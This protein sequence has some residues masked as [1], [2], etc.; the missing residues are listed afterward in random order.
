[1][2]V[3]ATVRMQRLINDILSYSRVGARHLKF[4]PVDCERVLSLAL[5]DMRSA[6]EE[7]GAVITHGPLPAVM[8]DETQMERLFDN[9]LG[10]AVKY[11]GGKTPA[12]H[13][14]AVEKPDE[15]LFN[16]RD[17]G[18]GIDPKYHD[19]IFIMFQRL[20]GKDEY[21]GTGIGLAICKKVV[22]NHG[23]RIWVESKPGHGSTFCFTIPHGRG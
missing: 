18:I 13:V 2:A 14:F 22:E 3:D 9:L 20:H 5:A 7:S 4:K 16:F 21:S 1:Y 15:W 12:I 6:I 17:N 10:N 19:R 8:T 23:G 11:C